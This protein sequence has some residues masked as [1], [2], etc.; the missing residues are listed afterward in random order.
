MRL[1]SILTLLVACS[2]PSERVYALDELNVQRFTLGLPVRGDGKLVVSASL[3][4]PAD[5]STVRGHAMFSCDDCTLGDDRTPLRDFLWAGPEGIPFG[6]VT[7][8]SVYGRADFA[9]GRLNVRSEWRSPDLEVEGKVDGTLAKQ[10]DDIELIGC[11][12]FRPT[13]ALLERDPKLY[14]LF[15]TTG[16]E[17]DEQGWFDISIQGRLAD[18]RRLARP[19]E[20][21]ISDR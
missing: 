5:W 6:H 20:L 15:G 9:D 3:I 13:Q 2:N 18:A 4:A 11:V 16:A 14:A 7:F 8:D 21:A 17:M 1:F 12:K 19:C 10:E